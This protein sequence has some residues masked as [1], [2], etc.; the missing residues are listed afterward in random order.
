M[1]VFPHIFYITYIHREKMLNMTI[2][3]DLNHENATEL[4]TEQ[5]QF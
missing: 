3:F 4:C 2:L 5:N 1:V